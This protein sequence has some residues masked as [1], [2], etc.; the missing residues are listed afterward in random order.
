M[1]QQGLMI[2]AFL[3]AFLHSG[4][5]SAKGAQGFLLTDV[6][7]HLMATNPGTTSITTRQD[8]LT[9]SSCTRAKARVTCTTRGL[10]PETK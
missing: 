8:E 4:L 9:V 5:T 2:T 6:S 1:K 10:S 7:C 3:S